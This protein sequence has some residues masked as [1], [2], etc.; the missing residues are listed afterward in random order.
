MTR[1]DLV[2][3]RPG[4]GR[5]IAIVVSVMVSIAALIAYLVVGADG[6]DSDDSR[7]DD[8]PTPAVA[9][10]DPPEVIRTKED[11]ARAAKRF[12]PLY[13]NR[14]PGLSVKELGARLEPVVTERFM[15]GSLPL[16][17]SDQDRE[18]QRFG[19]SVRAN[20]GKRL[21]HGDISPDG[22]YANVEVDVTVVV[23]DDEGDVSTRHTYTQPLTLVND[24]GRWE[25]D[26]LL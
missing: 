17:W 3:S 19:W 15:T 23:Y 5:L 18:M 20:P 9:Q 22:T 14:D 7:S 6:A 10:Q 2:A 12:V 8:T 24:E 1:E 4:M 26:N 11:L 25:V 13:L 21:H 16:A